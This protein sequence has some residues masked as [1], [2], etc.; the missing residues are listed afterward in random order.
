MQQT[1]IQSELDRVAKIVGGSPWG[2]DRGKPRIYLRSRRDVK[3]WLDYADAS[4]H[5][6]G[7]ARLDAR[8]DDCGQ[9]EAWYA[10]QRRKA[11]ENNATVALA[12]MIARGGQ[13]DELAEQVMDLDGELDDRIDELAGLAA[14]ARYDEIRAICAGV[15]GGAA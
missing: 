1:T 13:H 11:I 6:L 15:I 9:T 5:D 8:V 2:A 14:N 3:V 10:S 12:A 4:E 7:G